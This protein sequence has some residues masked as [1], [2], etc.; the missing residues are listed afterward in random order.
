MKSSFDGLVQQRNRPQSMDQP[1]HNTDTR[2][3]QTQ[4]PKPFMHAYYNVRFFHPKRWN[5]NDSALARI[6]N[7]LAEELNEYPHLPKYILIIPDKDIVSDT[8]V[9][10]YGISSTFEE[11]V[12]WLLTN[13]AEDLEKRKKNLHKTRPGALTQASEPCLV[14]VQMLN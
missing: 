7:G 9:F 3:L 10:D 14:W 8:K 5:S 12:E 1:L 6:Y 11:L 13:I 4:R 2:H